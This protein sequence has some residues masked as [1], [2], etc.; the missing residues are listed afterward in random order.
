VLG[1]GD[2][3][4]VAATDMVRRGRAEVQAIDGVPSVGRSWRPGG[5]SQTREAHN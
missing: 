3:A 2:V 1:S 4:V 5:W